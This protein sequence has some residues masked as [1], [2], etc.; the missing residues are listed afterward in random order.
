MQFAQLC[1]AA[2]SEA[3]EIMLVLGVTAKDKG[4]QLEALVHAALEFEGFVDVYSN[5][6]AAGGNELDVVGKREIGVIGAT[7]V[8]HLLCEAKAYA[9]PVDM[10]TWQRFLGKLLLSRSGKQKT[11]GILVALNGVNGNVR[12]SFEALR[13]DD[14]AVFILDGN[15]LLERARNNG[16]ISDRATAAAEIESAFKREV[17]RL[18]AAYYGAGYFWVAWWNDEEYSVVDAYGKRLA[19][20]KVESLRAAL[21]GALGGHLLASD[22]AQADLERRHSLKVEFIGRMLE[23]EH[24]LMDDSAHTDASDVISELAGEPYCELTDGQLRLIPAPALE[25]DDVARFFVSLFEQVVP[26]RQLQFV[27]DSHHDRYIERLIETLPARQAGF[28]LS[29][30]D[31]VRL[32]ALAPLFPSVWVALAHPMPM[33]TVHRADGVE[34]TDESILA[35]DRNAFWDAIIEYVR[36]DFTN[37]FLRGFLYDHLG[38]AELQEKIEVT[39]KSKRGVVATVETETRTSIGQ[40]SDEFAGEAGTRHVMIRLLPTV[41]EPWEQSH[42]TAIPLREPVEPGGDVEVPTT[43]D[44]GDPDLI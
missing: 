28:A 1:Q 18:E 24:I 21:S 35:A 36:K 4:G 15:Q 19:V 14:D 2:E 33:I 16:E 30:D 38:V 31:L 26:V 10:P 13:N 17:A 5:V 7:H 12:G 32:R 43:P 42:P 23:H 22:E 44:S 25:A 20:E 3:G 8:V 39:V 29:E 6:I 34:V 9:D 37:V 27:I 11:V 40:L 41:Q